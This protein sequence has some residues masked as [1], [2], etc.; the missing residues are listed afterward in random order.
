MQEHGKTECMV[1]KMQDKRFTVYKWLYLI[2]VI[3]IV[4]SFWNDFHFFDFS[5]TE[6][7][8]IFIA[9]GNPHVIPF[10]IVLKILFVVIL[11]AFLSYIAYCWMKVL[12]GDQKIILRLKMY[13]LIG[14][15]YGIIFIHI[16]PGLWYNN[17]DELAVFNYARCLQIQ[18]HQSAMMAICYMLALMFWPKPAMIVV[19]QL[20]IGTLVLGN[21]AADICSKNRLQAFFL[22]TVF[23][24]AGLYYANYPM[25]AYLFSVF[26]LAFVHYWLK[27]QGRKMTARELAIIVFILCIVI[28]FRTEAKFLLVIFP[29][30]LIGRCT[31]KQLVCSEGLLLFSM[32]IISGINLLGNQHSYQSHSSIM[33]VAPLSIYFTSNRYDPR[34]DSDV[35]AID[36]VLYVDDI[37]K[38]ASYF[39]CGGTRSD[40]EY[41]DE[42]FKQYLK[43]SVNIFI[44]NPDIYIKAK[45]KCLFDSIGLSA[46][47][48]FDALSGM[49]S[50]S[51]IGSEF[52]EE[53]HDSVKDSEPYFKDFDRDSHNLF[54]RIIAGQYKIG[55][56]KTYCIY[57]SF[58][59]PCLLMII[60]VVACFRK[61]R[62]LAVMGSIVLCHLC[63]TMLAAPTRVQMYYFPEYLIGWYLVMRMLE[64]ISSL[65]KYKTSI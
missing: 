39:Y 36:K 1:E 13:V 7:G 50:F 60:V 37:K 17:F 15:V 26:F 65:R 63:L 5:Y 31:C 49:N 10:Y 2:G 64:V 59:L 52:P 23:S 30:L 18:C 14:V 12:E 58:W 35:A 6:R 42:E 62:C 22:L 38:N 3:E 24:P 28:N 54:T 55:K 25:R 11:Y 56:I 48:R 46:L 40:S 53:F 33:V 29:L 51:W 61:K 32:V 4:F 21:I 20:V 27:F 45:L 34:Y 41:S 8:T 19:F 57:Y 47:N 9:A 43:S 16:Y 44:H